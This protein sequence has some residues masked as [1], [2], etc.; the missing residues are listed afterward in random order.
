MT[1]RRRLGPRALLSLSLVLAAALAAAD[2]HA[3]RIAAVQQPELR[4]W[5]AR[6]DGMLRD[7]ELRLRL[8][9]DDTLIPG[10]SHQR[11]TQ[12]YEG[13]P[14]FGGELVRQTDGREAVS[15]FGTL[16]EGIAIDPRPAL[17]LE[18]AKAIVER[19][20][21]VRLGPARA[22]ELVVL[23]KQDG[24][25]ALSYRLRAF[26]KKDLV[27]FFID[28]RTGAEVLR[29]SDLKSDV[30]VGLGKGVLGDTKKLSTTSQGGAFEAHDQLRPPA[31]FTFDMKGDLVRTIDFL[32][33][34]LDLTRE[35]LA[36]DSDNNWTDGANVDGHAYAGWVYDYYFK[37]FGR[38]G[39]DN[40]NI[41]MWSLVHP[42]N[43]DDL[44]DYSGEIIGLFYLN[45]FYFGDGIMVYGEGLPS[46][47][48]F[49]DRKWNFFSAGLDI[50]GHELT[51][52]VTDF[53]SQLIYQDESGAL[54]EA[55]SDM[56]GTSVEFFFQP[57]GDGLLKA[58]YLI[59]EDVATPGGFRSMR[60]PQAFGDPDHYSRRF[61]GQDDNGGVHINSG[62]PNNAFYLAIEGGTNATSGIAVQGVG[63]ANRD[64]IEKTFY[65][66]FTQM[67]PP[68]ANFSTARAATIQ[69]ARD[70]FG[71]GS[72]S[73]RAVTQAW[74]AVGVN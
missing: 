65:R 9:R 46:G 34:D 47:F 3:L 63:A 18:Q 59:A 7:G 24:G 58:D 14:V 13:V 32:N 48:T 73:E 61:I 44:F 6:I 71:A 5:D 37:R 36:R 29:Y 16:Y 39:L 52:G 33:G 1:L 55:F 72:A 45:A 22:P 11:F 23:P 15:V 41:A 56:M 49:L 53:S 62:I 54:N 27:M 70:L 30:A 8:V 12:L 38:L 19:L 74:T 10:R 68:S 2:P 42:V 35:D 20:S 28:A 51:H 31:I 60:N 66:A 4:G 64:Q 26:T 43:R 21:G 57:P 69:S 67:L 50:V 25:Y 17:S 40:D